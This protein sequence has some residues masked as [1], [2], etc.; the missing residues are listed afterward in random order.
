MT[1]K[2]QRPPGEAG[3]RVVWF[4]LCRSVAAAPAVLGSL[5][6]LMLASG[7]LGR[8]AA[9]LPLTWVACAAVLLNPGGE[10][11]AVR[12]VRRFHRPGPAQAAA[13]E[14]TWATALRVTGTAAADV[15]LYVQ[16]TR[17]DP[18]RAQLA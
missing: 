7:A 16:P 4:G 9:T 10:R 2:R 5:L 17:A 12:A 14:S 13:L 15:E 3:S 11:M 6:L 18:G 8:W 1:T